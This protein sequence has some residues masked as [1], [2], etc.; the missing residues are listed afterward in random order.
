MDTDGAKAY[1]TMD[2]EGAKIYT[3]PPEAEP[4]PPEA[5]RLLQTQM[6]EL[7][8]FFSHF[9]SA[10]I[11]AFMLTGQQLGIWA[12]LGILA[13]VVL[14]SMLAT[15]TVLLFTGLSAAVAWLFDTHVWLGQVILGGGVLLLFALGTVLGVRIRKHKTL[16]Q[17][18]QEYDERQH[19][20]RLAYGHSVVD[21]ATAEAIQH[22]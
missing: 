1:S 10:K 3:T 14:T 13:L 5:V 7:L 15:A 22:Q 11:D 4:S 12:V 8:A 19:Q 2:T 16:Q 20:Q 17:K 6:Q 18:V 9:V 21:R